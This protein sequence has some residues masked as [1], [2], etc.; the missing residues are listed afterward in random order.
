MDSVAPMGDGIPD[1]SAEG[2]EKHFFMVS[3]YQ[4]RLV[5]IDPGSWPVNQQVDYHLVR[6]EMNAREFF[7]KV[8]RPWAKDPGFYTMR[9][10][11]AGASIGAPEFFAPVK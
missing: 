2:I 8:H 11:D 9:T 10:G 4:Q 7:H 1:Y 6:A 5:Q 3:D